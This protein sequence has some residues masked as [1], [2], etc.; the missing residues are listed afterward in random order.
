M[1]IFKK[2]K[3]SNR[4][5]FSISCS[6]LSCPS[7]GTLPRPQRVTICS[8]LPQTVH[9]DTKFQY[10][11]LYQDFQIQIWK[12]DFLTTTF[13]QVSPVSKMNFLLDVLVTSNSMCTK[14]ALYTLS[15]ILQYPFFSSL[16]ETELSIFA[17]QKNFWNKKLWVCSTSEK[18][19]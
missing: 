12:P 13:S 15:T 17:Q 2:L 4:F 10:S 6:F 16:I 11:T 3:T 7:Q 9:L 19:P 8:S 18:F 1:Y 14:A 5:S